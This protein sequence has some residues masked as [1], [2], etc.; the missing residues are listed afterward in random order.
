MVSDKNS[1]KNQPSD[2]S[3][4]EK[5]GPPEPAR[6]QPQS[7]AAEQLEALRADRDANQQKY[8]L[9]VADFE[10]YRR[11]VQKEREDDRRFAVLPLARDLLP[12]LDNLQRALD[13]AR[14]SPDAAGLTAGVQMVVKQL[15]DILARHGVVRIAAI[16]QPFDPNLHQAIQQTPSP[17][18]P[19][20]TVLAEFERGYKMH[21]RVVRPSTV[22]VSAPQGQNDE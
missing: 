20:L 17:D 7:A 16:D 4:E 22:V 11:R 18:K 10:N 6:G 21:D 13:A 19:P 3:P 1:P 14:A 2:R 12:V 9:A 15:D 8:L 5:S